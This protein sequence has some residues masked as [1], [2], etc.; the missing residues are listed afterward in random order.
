[1]LRLKEN[2]S[3]VTQNKQSLAEENRQL[4]QLL[5]Q[6]GIPWTGSGGVDEFTNDQSLGHRSSD[7]QNGSYAAGSSTFSPPP[8]SLSTNSNP[9]SAHY[10]TGSPQMSAGHGNYNADNRSTAQ[11][12]AQG[13]DYDQAGIDFVLTYGQDFS[14]AYLSTPPQ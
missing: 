1:M 14:H 5:A 4:K 10:D 3:I 8:L 12:Q 2:F 9:N 6:H 11:Q 7:S 13:V